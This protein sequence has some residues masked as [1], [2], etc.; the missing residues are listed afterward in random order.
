MAATE[1]SMAATITRLKDPDNVAET[2]RQFAEL[3]EKISSCMTRMF[4]YPKNGGNPFLFALSGP[5]PHFLVEKLRGQEI[6]TAAT[7]GKNFFWNPGFLKSL[8]TNQVQTVMSH[9]SYHVLFFHCSPDRSMGKNPG[10]WNIAVDYVVNGVIEHDHE[11]SGRSAAFQLWGGT[12]GTP[13]SFS[14]YLDWI[15]G[16]KDKVPSPCMFAD[17]TMHGRSPESI[18]D[19]IVQAKLSSPRRCKENSGG[20][21]A[22]SMD[23][24]TGKSTIP[25]PWDQDA[26]QKCGAKP[27]HGPQ[28]MDSHLPSDMT[29]DEVMGEMMRA[30]EQAEATGRGK[31]PAEVEAALSELKKPTLR[32]HDIIRQAFMRKAIDT[33]NKNDWK[34][35]RRRQLAMTPRMY[36]P[37]KHDHTPRWI[38]LL[39]TSGSMSDADIANGLKEMQAVPKNSEGWVVPCDAQ[40]YWEDKTLVRNT[41]E[42][43]RTKVVGRGGTV[44][45]QFFEELPK[46][47]GLDFDIVVIITD[48][49]CDHIPM[50]LKPPFDVLWVI[51]NKRDFNPTFG[52][53][54]QLRSTRG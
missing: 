51:T 8:D 38:C 3:S 48:G 43:K 39:D 32:P 26:C 44:F 9:E 35:L 45:E 52:R 27:N 24:K 17:P 46:E 37:R 49:D 21:G 31:A 20:C 18:Y 5:K 54:V 50:H 13:V 40:P 28:S 12:L 30:S 1:K 7:D 25:Q 15:A 23:P 14:D 53:V 47:M 10:D 42:L 29:K 16:K 36:L 6:S 19:D 33:G 11:K 22:M 2:P 41:T 34:R 4:Q